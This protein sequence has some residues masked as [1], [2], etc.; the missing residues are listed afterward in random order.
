MYTFKEQSVSTVAAPSALYLFKNLEYTGCALTSSQEASMLI[1]K[2]VAI[3]IKTA[4]QMVYLTIRC[5]RICTLGVQK[6]F[7]CS[8]F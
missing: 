4:Y 1:E 3:R 5:I 7:E 6:C 8:M 2:F